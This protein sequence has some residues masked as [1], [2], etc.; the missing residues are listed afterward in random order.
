MDSIKSQSYYREILDT[1][2]KHSLVS[3]S[4]KWNKFRME[5]IF[6]TSSYYKDSGHLI[7][8][9]IINELRRYG[10]NHSF[11]RSR[12]RQRELDNRGD[13]FGYPK[14]TLVN[15]NIGHL[16][17]PRFDRTS[18]L[19]RYLYVDSALRQ[20]ERLD[21]SMKVRGWI[22][23][24]RDNGGGSMYPMLAS[25]QAF[26]E[27]DSLG[28]FVNKQG[29]VSWWSILQ[30]PRMPEQRVRKY[31]CQNLGKK[32]AVLI[33]KDTKSAAE[34]TAISLIDKPYVK[35]IGQASGGYTTANR[36]FRLSNG[37]YLALATSWSSDSKEK[38]YRGKLIPDITTSQTEAL[39][40]AI[41]WI[42]Q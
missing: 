21:H 33:N 28:Y 6:L 39:D 2:E 15:E 1:I 34:M 10:D 8:T 31:K 25:I 29:K 16:T 5:I 23:D 19:D 3:D 35:L 38:I 18:E 27:D 11:W 30:K 40:K 37:S 26:M 20:I 9:R 7:I 32:V 17:I 42:D 36:R 13:S 14:L 24:L 12:N 22:I 4:I 41:Q